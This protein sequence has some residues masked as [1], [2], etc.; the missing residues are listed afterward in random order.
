MAFPNKRPKEEA[1]EEG[2]K[3]DWV[4]RA[5]QSPG[6][7]H[8]MTAGVAWNVKVNS[9]DALSVKLNA[10]PVNFDGSLLILEPLPD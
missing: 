2:K 10:L 7:E 4:I 9:K 3:P 6:S 5:R 8:F 1:R